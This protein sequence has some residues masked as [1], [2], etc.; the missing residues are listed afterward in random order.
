MYKTFLLLPL[1]AVCIGCASQSSVNDLSKQLADVNV[2][3]TKIESAERQK[4]S[5]RASLEGA[6]N[7]ANSR[8]LNCRQRAEDNFNNWVKEN[9]TPVE[10]HKGTY[11]VGSENGKQAQETEA[12]A[13][14][15]C[16]KQYEDD[17]QTAK[18]RYSD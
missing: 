1:L 3:L 10:G 18:M 8:R 6:I 16:Q 14:A 4:S 9:G 7:S 11:N 13:F 15:D 12:R 5:D 2:R 17:L